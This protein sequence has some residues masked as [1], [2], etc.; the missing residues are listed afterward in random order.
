[1]M[2]NKDLKEQVDLSAKRIADLICQ[3][4]NI[5]GEMLHIAS[6]PEGKNG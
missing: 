6:M 1:M 5:C 4:I 3:L 2:D